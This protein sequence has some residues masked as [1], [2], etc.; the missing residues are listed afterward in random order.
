MKIKLN[1]PWNHKMKWYK[2]DC[3]I[4]DNLDMRKLIDEWGWD[5]FGRYCAIIG[6][7]GMLVTEKNQTFALQTNDGSPFPV[8]LLAN[9]CSTTVERLSDFCKYLANNRLIDKDAWYD[10]NLIF[11]PKLR[12]RADEY[13]KKLSFHKPAYLKH[14]Q[15]LLILVIS[16]ILRGSK[17]NHLTFCFGV[18]R[19]RDRSADIFPADQFTSNRRI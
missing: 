11:I 10:K 13:T 16:E 15:K 12:E 4:Q 9:D 5:W 3:D 17:I 8:K 7:V 2:M 18:G 6:K 14:N 1:L 19:Q